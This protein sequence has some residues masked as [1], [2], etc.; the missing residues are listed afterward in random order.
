MV[1]FAIDSPD[2]GRLI[3]IHHRTEFTYSRPAGGGVMILRQTPLSGP[4]Q[5]VQSWDT[6]IVGG[7]RQLEQKDQFGN[8]VQLVAISPGSHEIRVESFGTVG[9]LSATPDKVADQ[10]SLP[11]WIY[12]RPT[13]QTEAGRAVK[14]IVAGFD[15][16]QLNCRQGLQRLSQ[17]VLQRIPYTHNLT[18]AG[19]T[20]EDA[21]RTKAGVCQDHAHVFIA[22]CRMHKLPV[23]YVGGYLLTT[24][25]TQHEAGHAWV[26]VHLKGAGW[27]GFDISNGVKPDDRYVRT[28]VGRDY[29][30]AAPI[31]GVRR[32]PGIE[33]LEVDVRIRQVFAGTEPAG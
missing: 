33:Q 4:Q 18:H 11:L 12:C 5:Q 10:G 19:T 30:D 8:H 14:S 15:L 3:E 25:R 21:A 16:E 27:V 20:A 28:A 9:T 26:E 2:M 29:A 17:Q 1:Q 7:V 23:R 13:R 6:Q 32:G 24:D 22:I 31:T